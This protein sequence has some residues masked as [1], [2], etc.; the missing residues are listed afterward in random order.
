MHTC[1]LA[2][3]I[4]ALSDSVLKLLQLLSHGTEPMDFGS[5]RGVVEATNHSVCLVLAFR[6]LLE[7]LKLLG[8]VHRF[9]VVME[10]GRGVQGF[11]I[12]L[13]TIVTQPNDDRV[14]MEYDLHILRLPDVAV[15][16][17]DGE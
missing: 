2:P 3:P 1:E 14:G 7:H 16:S 9:P 5:E 15:G 8:S 17:L 4:L 10:D 11:R 13:V 6:P 12:H